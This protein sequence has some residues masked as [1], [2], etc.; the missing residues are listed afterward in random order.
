M[1]NAH[2][3]VDVGSS[4]TCLLSR[5][6]RT[7]ASRTHP[8][9]ICT[10][11]LAAHQLGPTSRLYLY[12][13]LPRHPSILP[14][15]FSPSLT[16]AF[17]IH[18][19]IFDHFSTALPTITIATTITT[20]TTTTNNNQQ[21]QSQWRWTEIGG[22]EVDGNEEFLS[23]SIS[24]FLALSLQHL[25]LLYPSMLFTTTIPSVVC[26]DTRLLPSAHSFVVVV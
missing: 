15:L 17:F 8:S 5:P 23:L 2:V 20:T 7:L 9:R 3:D 21:S 24:I 22:G 10:A 25:S 12:A 4:P 18:S 16:D 11:R 14:P 1:V 6:Q 13:P 26:F 19:F